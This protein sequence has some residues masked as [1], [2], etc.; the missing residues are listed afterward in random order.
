[1]WPALSANTPNGSSG[2]EPT[3]ESPCTNESRWASSQRSNGSS[4]SVQD[5]RS[6]SGRQSAQEIE[7]SPRVGTTSR[8]APSPRSWSAIS[9]AKL[10][11]RTPARGNFWRNSS[12]MQTSVSLNSGSCAQ[13][14]TLSFFFSLSS[15]AQHVPLAPSASGMLGLSASQPAITAS[16]DASGRTEMAAGSYVSSGFALVTNSFVPS[17]RTSAPVGK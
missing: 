2:I 1:N 15:S 3:S 4:A 5:S 13:Q 14:G 16:I 9:E 10:P 6:S 7:G 8:S 17:G 12:S 11:I